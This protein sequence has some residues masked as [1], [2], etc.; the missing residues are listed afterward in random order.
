MLAIRKYIEWAKPKCNTGIA[1]LCDNTNVIHTTRR[2]YS[3]SISLRDEFNKLA[4]LCELMS[5]KCCMSYVNT[6]KNLMCDLGSRCRPALGASIAEVLRMHRRKH[7]ASLQKRRQ[8]KAN[9]ALATPSITPVLTL[10]TWISDLDQ[11]FVDRSGPVALGLTPSSLTQA[12]L[13]VDGRW[14]TI[15]D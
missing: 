5:I 1:F 14:P 10:S 6:K 13:E 11:H 9:A 4:D 8:D 7:Q 15:K 2:G 3:K 12:L